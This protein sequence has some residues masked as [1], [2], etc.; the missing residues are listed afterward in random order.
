MS[1]FECSASALQ[2]VCAVVPPRPFYSK[3]A[4][5]SSPKKRPGQRPLAWRFV[6]LVREQAVRLPSP[7]RGRRF[8]LAAGAEW[9]SL[10]R[11]GGFGAGLALAYPVH[12]GAAD[13]TGTRG[14]RPPVLK[15][16]LLRVAHLS[17]G[18]TLEAIS[19]H[20]KP[21]LL[22][23][24]THVPFLMAKHYAFSTACQEGTPPK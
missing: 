16:D 20:I 21:P 5:A 12:L 19:L 7:R 13:W 9:A 24:A 6:C 2:A 17:L 15:G 1:T 3:K 22:G 10:N 14:S 11:R 18:A 23:L 8:R 4:K